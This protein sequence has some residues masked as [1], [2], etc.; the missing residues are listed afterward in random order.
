MSWHKP[1]FM[2]IES[3]FSSTAINFC[4]VIGFLLLQPAYFASEADFE[5]SIDIELNFFLKCLILTT[6]KQ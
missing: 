3:N 5:L 1:D 6:C 4:T 2:N